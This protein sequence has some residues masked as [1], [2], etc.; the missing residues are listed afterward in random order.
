MMVHRMKT[1]KANDDVLAE[2]LSPFYGL[3]DYTQAQEGRV[4]AIN[5]GRL[6]DFL[7]IV[8]NCVCCRTTSRS[9]SIK[10]VMLK[11][12]PGLM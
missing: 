5:E 10:K 11:L 8:L 3:N 1:T 9:T 4:I 2:F 12:L 7:S 6:V